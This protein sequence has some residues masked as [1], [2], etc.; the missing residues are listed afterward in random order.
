MKRRFRPV[1]S[2]RRPAPILFAALSCALFFCGA[3]AAFAAAAAH[4]YEGTWTAQPGKS[5]GKTKAAAGKTENADLKLT[6]QRGSYE[7]RRGEKVVEQGIYMPGNGGSR[8]FDVLARTGA[9]QGRIVRVIYELREDILKLYAAKSGGARPAFA[10]TRDRPAVYRRAGNAKSAKERQA[11][12]RETARKTEDGKT[13]GAKKEQP[14]ARKG[15]KV[16]RGGDPLA[17]FTEEQ[18]LEVGFC[19]RAFVTAVEHGD[20]ETAKAFLWKVPAHLARL[21]LSK[22]ADRRTFLAAYA[23]Y[24]GAR[25]VKSMRMAIAGIGIVTYT[26]KAGA[27]REQRMKNVAG[28]WKI[29]E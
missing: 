11:P 17:K 3:E 12:G 1:R 29:S 25:L 14:A 5:D 27:E 9:A 20:A 24:K 22:Q 6:M 18:L 16:G 10:G 8:A 19:F 15:E 2:T 26:T 7:V 28:R 13:Q 4:G 21:D 23:G